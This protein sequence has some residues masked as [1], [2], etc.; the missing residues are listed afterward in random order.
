MIITKPLNNNVVMAK[1]RSSQNQ[2]LRPLRDSCSYMY[3]FCRR[4][5]AKRRQDSRE[6]RAVQS[7]VLVL[8]QEGRMLFVKYCGMCQRISAVLW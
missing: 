2:L 8:L 7:S 1:D 3:S 4:Q 6:Q 5:Q